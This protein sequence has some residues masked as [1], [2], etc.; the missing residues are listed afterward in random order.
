MDIKDKK[1][2]FSVRKY[3]TGTASILLGT[4]LALGIANSNEANAAEETNE[5]T[6]VTAQPTTSENQKPE[7]ATQTNTGEASVP[8]PIDN[9]IETNVVKKENAKESIQLQTSTQEID[10]TENKDAVITEVSDS[11]DDTKENISATPRSIQASEKPAEETNTSVENIKNEQSAPDDKSDQPPDST[12][13]KIYIDGKTPMLEEDSSTT[14]NKELKKETIQEGKDIS[15]K[16]KIKKDKIESKDAVNPQQGERVTLKYD[17][18]FENGINPGDYFDFTISNNVNT[19]GV[20][21]IKKVPDIKNGSITMATGKVMENGKIRYTFLDYIQNKV[22][23]TANLSLNLFLDPRTVK[24]DGEQTITSTLNGH[25]TSK[26]INVKHLNGISQ[27]G[28]EVNGI[29]E[30]LDKDNNKFTHISVVNPKGYNIQ[31]PIIH[32]KVL[33]GA[34]SSNKQANVKIYEYIGKENLPQSL[35][36]NFSNTNLFKE[37]S[38]NLKIELFNDGSYR[39]N[40]DKL[41]K[42]YVIKYEGSYQNDAEDL[43]FRTT[44]SGYSP[45]YYN[46]YSYASWD[47][48]LVLYQNNANGNG[49]NGPIIDNNDINWQEDTLPDGKSGHNNGETEEEDSKPIEWDEHTV[50]DDESGHNNGETE[51][52]D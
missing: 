28:I 27:A 35:S 24:N 37:I 16:V 44:F 18:E 50:P 49:K 43:I 36:V 8:A 33:K 7:T 47:N 12:D 29:M 4:C 34:P 30:N 9:K 52:E 22:N 15:N 6:T 3:K 25:E 40:L 46:Y 20:S 26:T 48:G 2:K 42:T 19:N 10:S 39:I 17:W 23:V 1:F 41:D 5:E 51:E 13:Y 38:K 11:K 31:Y 21:V 45:F 14:P 32:G